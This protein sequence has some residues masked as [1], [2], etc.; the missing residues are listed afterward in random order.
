M[1][2]S[3]CIVALA[4]LATIASAQDFSLTIV[5]GAGA[6]SITDFSTF[7]VEIYGDASVGTHMVG[8]S[9]GVEAMT[10]NFEVLDMRWNPAAW[11]AFNDDG[12]TTG[13][14]NYDQVIFGQ[15]VIPGVPPFDVPAPGSA[16]GSLIGTFEIDVGEHGSFWSIDLQLTAQVPFSLQVVDIDTG[17]TFLSTDGNLALGSFSAAFIPAPSSLALIGLGGL[18]AGRRRR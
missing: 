10:N 8:G 4:G 11:S 2:K 13:G 12:G 1:K 5:G 9:F 15:L 17:E 16:L 3:C 14:G 18:A 6:A 7:E